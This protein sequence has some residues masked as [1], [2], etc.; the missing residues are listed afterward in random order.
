[1]K[2]VTAYPVVINKVRKSPNDY[3][4]AFDGAK[5][6]KEQLSAFQKWY[7]ANK[8]SVSLSVNEDGSLDS[9]TKSAISQMGSKYDKLLKSGKTAENF[10][11]ATDVIGKVADTLGGL[12]GKKDTIPSPTPD[13]TPTPNKKPKSS[14]TWMWVV[15][16]LVALGAIVLL[17]RKP[18]SK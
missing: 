3:Y 2:L 16:G 13:V 10:G 8:P 12:F 4:L 14:S 7:N 11:K 9:A 5:A 17:V 18:K 6:T 15:G 1:M